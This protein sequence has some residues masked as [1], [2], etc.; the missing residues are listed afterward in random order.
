MVDVIAS[1]HLCLDLYPGMKHVP[2]EAVASPGKLFE[3][4]ALDMATGGSVSNTGLALHRLGADVA[5][6]GTVGSD[7][8][9]RVI[10]AYLRDQGPHLGEHVKV[11]A[12][13]D[14]SYTVVLSPANQDR[15]LLH[16]AGSNTTFGIEDVDFEL[17]GE[18]KIFHLGYPPLLPRLYANEGEELLEIYRRAQAAGVL[19]SL[20]M[21]LPDLNGTS[22][23]VDWQQIIQQTMPH[24]DVFLPSAEEIVLMLRRDDYLAWDG[25]VLSHLTQAYVDSLLNELLALGGAVVGIKLG[26]YGFAA[27]C[28]DAAERLQTLSKVPVQLEQWQGHSSYHPA[29]DVEVV[30]T[31]GAGD[32]AYAAFLVSM[33]HGLSL[34]EAVKMACAVGAYGVESASS[35]QS[36]RSWEETQQRITS[37]WATRE[38]HLP[39]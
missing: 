38:K 1:G 24:I 31:T 30:G 14:S 10:I 39:A 15:I 12:D 4:E 33:L 26:E 34:A 23:Q 6:M 11:Q 28:S 20:D 29:F 13:E 9:G 36:V 32:S 2:L 25:E 3:T 22:G 16:C 21:A 8:L 37:G 7:L 18:A 5:L 19:T 35:S 17:V 27:R